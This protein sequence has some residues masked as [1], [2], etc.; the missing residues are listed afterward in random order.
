M[1]RNETEK[2]KKIRVILTALALVLAV[3]LSGALL[4]APAFA[5]GTVGAQS[6]NAGTRKAV[7]DDPQA[8]AGEVEMLQV[9]PAQLQAELDAAAPQKLRFD[10][11]M[12]T[13]QANLKNIRKG[14]NLTIPVLI[15][16]PSDQYKSEFQ[17]YVKGTG[18]DWT[19]PE[20]VWPGES[21]VTLT[22]L[23]KL[24]Y[25]KYRV[26]IRMRRVCG[27]TVGAWKT[28]T[29]KRSF[30]YEAIDY[31]ALAVNEAR[32]YI[33]ARYWAGME[34][35]QFTDCSGLVKMAWKPFGVRLWHKSDCQVNAHFN[36]GGTDRGLAAQGVRFK[37]IADKPNKAYKSLKRA[38]PGDVLYWKGSP[39]HWSHV[40]IYSG[41]RKGRHWIIDCETAYWAYGGCAPGV[42]EHPI[43]DYGKYNKGRFRVRGAGKKQLD[44]IV[45]YY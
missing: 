21:S 13:R 39:G 14:R 1:Y 27:E 30:G 45:R 15:F 18:M 20:T 12:K 16:T 4:P 40:A 8:Y 3:A 36:Y 9:D 34:S 23:G 28:V 25:A 33:G 2:K 17:Y 43:G 31:G 32:K 11:K 35:R 19:Q 22:A 6:Q 42:T 37:V 29:V 10:P 38:R 24:P 7:A 5:M 41:Y 26:T 44:K